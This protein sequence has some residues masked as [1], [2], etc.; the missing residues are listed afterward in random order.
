MTPMERF[1]NLAKRQQDEILDK[2]R[3]Y[4]TEHLEWWDAVYDCFKAD[5]DKVGIYVYRMYFSGFYSQ[6]DGACFEGSVDDWPKFL[7][8]LGHTSP[9]LITLANTGWKFAVEHK[10]HYYHENCTRFDACLNTLDCHDADDDE[11]F[12]SVFSPYK[13]EIQ[14]AA[15]MALIAGYK[16]LD[17]EEELEEEFKSHMRDL[18][19]RL[20]VEYDALTSDESVLEALHAND[21]LD[22]IIDEL[23][24]EYA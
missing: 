8:S 9:A 22:E 24:N 7:E 21:M 3:H 4:N 17:I 16:R 12:A 1:K 19:N 15:W 6:G 11:D 23:E 2:H 18:Y 10:G 14:T 20:E 13:S 5:M